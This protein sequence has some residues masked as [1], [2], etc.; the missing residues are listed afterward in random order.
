MGAMKGKTGGR[1]GSQGESKG[2]TGGGG[3]IN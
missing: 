2:N 3:R 1:L